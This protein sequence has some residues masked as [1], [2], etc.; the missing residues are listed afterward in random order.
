MSEKDSSKLNSS[1][2]NNSAPSKR[3]S[4]NSSIEKK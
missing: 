2:A 3:S 1:N 4:Y